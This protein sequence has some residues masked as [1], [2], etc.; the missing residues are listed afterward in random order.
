MESYIKGNQNGVK[1]IEDMEEWSLDKLF[2]KTYPWTRAYL[3]IFEREE[4]I[5]NA[6]NFAVT[7][8]ETI[9][10][11]KVITEKMMIY[12]SNLDTYKQE[13]FDD[14]DDPRFQE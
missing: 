6:T 8:C 4:F 3:E 13:Y 11:L 1:N 14:P 10:I 2:L 5:G 9:G 7:I 12:F